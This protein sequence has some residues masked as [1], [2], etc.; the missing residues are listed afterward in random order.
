MYLFP[1]LFFQCHYNYGWHTL[2]LKARQN[3]LICETARQSLLIIPK[4]GAMISQYILS[5]T[6]GRTHIYIT[7]QFIVAVYTYMKSVYAV[8][9]FHTSY[10]EESLVLR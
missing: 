8:R 6:Y 10:V 2:R 3:T 4:R 1:T 9:K 5:H 7:Q